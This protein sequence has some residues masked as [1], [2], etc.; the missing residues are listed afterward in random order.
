[1]QNLQGI[2]L[3][4][5]AM[6]GFA[7]GDVGIK[8]L[9]VDLSLSQIVMTMGVLGTSFFYALSRLKRQPVLTKD[10][11]HPAIAIRTFAEIA[12]A[13]CMINAL[14]LT[15]L[16]LVT[17]VT[18]AGPLAVALGAVVFFREK[19]GWRRWCAIL[20]GLFG[21]LIILRPGT[22]GFNIL[23]LLSVGAMLALAARDLSTRAAPRSLSNLQ[24]AT[25]GFAAFNLAA[26]VLIP[27]TDPWRVPDLRQ[28]GLLALAVVPTIAGYY[29]ITAAMRIGDISVVTP[30]R[31]TRLL[32]GVCLGVLLFGETIDIWMITGGSLVVAS[33]IYTVLRERKLHRLAKADQQASL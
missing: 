13:L 26:L 5:L 10:L 21:V 16:S 23:A 32:F 9:S 11:A 2:T 30:F 4:I 6:A 7:L 25:V 17:S 3:M 12:A 33:G 31:Y 18:Q 24:L 14:A 20:T 27:F 28:T 8:A 29:A 19:V 22:E 1:M 15:P